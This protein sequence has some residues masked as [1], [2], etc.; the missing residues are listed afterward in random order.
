MQRDAPDVRQSAILPAASDHDAERLGRGERMTDRRADRVDA[1]LRCTRP[2]PLPD[3]DRMDLLRERRD[4]DR[5]ARE[6]ERGH[7]LADARVERLAGEQRRRACFKQRRGRELARA[8]R[9]DEPATGTAQQA[10]P[11]WG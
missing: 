9:R 5:L 6:Q 1:R 8:R 2:P 4:L 3:D 7:E 11:P 10:H